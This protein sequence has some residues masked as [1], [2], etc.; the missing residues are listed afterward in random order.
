M[1]TPLMRG[2]TRIAAAT[3]VAL[4]LTIG[5][6]A[7]HGPGSVAASIPPRTLI[8]M[9][10][11]VDEWDQRV[12]ETGPVDARRVFGADLLHMGPGMG[13]AASEVKAGRY[14]ILSFKVPGNDWAG[15]AAGKYDH[16]LYGLRDRL[17]AI[18]GRVF[19]TLHHEPCGDGTPS[20]YAAMQRH[21]LR[22]LRVPV[23]VDA[24]VI[25]NGFWWSSHPRQSTAVC[26]NGMTD[27]QIARWLPASVLTL[28]EV[29][30][31]DTYQAGTTTA[32]GEGAAPKIANL[33]RWATRV[34]V[35]RL[36]IGEY[37][38]LTAA[39]ITAA[40][41][42][43]L[44]DPRF[45][46]GAIFNSDR[47][48]RDGVSWLLTG[49]RLEAFKATLAKSRQQPSPTPS[50]TATP[51][52]TDTPTP[53]PTPTTPSSSDVADPTAPLGYPAHAV[54]LYYM[55]WPDSPSPR[56]ADIPT[57]VNVVNLAFAQGD[58][59]ALVGWGPTGQ[60]TFTADAAT[61]RAHGVRVVLSVGGGGGT[62]NPA[63]RT[64]FVN[65]IMAINAKVPLDGIDWDL[66]TSTPTTSDVVWISQ[67]LKQLRG[68]KFAVTL[69]PN[70]ANIDAY[71]PIAVALQNAGALDMI[72]QQFYD[73]VVSKEDA[74][75]RIGQLEAAG[76]TPDHI[77]VGMMVGTSDHY[78]TVDE[79]VTN[80][81]YLKATYPGL[82][83]GYLWEASRAGTADW[84]NRVGAILTTS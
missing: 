26:H 44:R 31:A 27:A 56:L 4:V 38:G 2:V 12:A 60:A 34:G 79:C 77:G 39:S 11:P 64:A 49:D 8:G 22:I 28:A 32:P 57:G 73:A 20:D 65:G 72:G 54:G 78:W 50:P 51:T 3:V 83:G 18:P 16:Q 5:G 80:T 6:T 82:R 19:V 47:N 36:G 43:I 58:P 62:A 76:I 25:V 10:S 81:Q 37:N 45:V 40:G 75:W 55:M 74:A 17:A 59:P 84:V 23:N 52:P 1:L 7:S 53:T 42:A 66:E 48:N 33:S 15:V 69:A 67:R 9:S 63:N 30:A 35:N 24:G 29:V 68:P 46:F 61:L 70:G 71:R 14:P 21:A 41:D 13:L